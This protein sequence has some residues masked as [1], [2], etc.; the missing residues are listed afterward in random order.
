MS[1]DATRPA[2]VSTLSEQVAEEIRV[3]L[4]RRRMSQ[5]ELARR[6]DTSGAWLNYRLTGKQ[7]IDLNDLDRIAAALGV[8]PAE[9][10]AGPTTPKSVPP[11]F[12]PPVTRPP[13]R[14]DSRRPMALRHAA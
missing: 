2:R 11:P 1:I 7:P 8:K 4:A 13:G 3:L 14:N 10:L 12:R 5:A 9:L 6:L